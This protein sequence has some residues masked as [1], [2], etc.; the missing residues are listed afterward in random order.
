MKNY[1]ICRNPSVYGDRFAN[2]WDDL[3]NDQIMT[4]YPMTNLNFA[5]DVSGDENGYTIEADLP[6]VNK[7]DV[8][9]ELV[10]NQLTI[11]VDSKKESKEEKAGYIRKERRE[12][13]SKRT[14]LLPDSDGEGVEARLADGVLTVSVPK[15]KKEELTKKIEIQ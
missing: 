9:I 14:I 8:R 12:I 13:A 4:R 2:L 11:S 15:V 1:M 3:F 10:N 6:G 5:L 7:D